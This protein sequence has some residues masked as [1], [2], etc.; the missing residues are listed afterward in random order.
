MKV[1]LL[2]QP[3]GKNGRAPW[4]AAGEVVD[5]DDTKGNFLVRHGIAELAGGAKREP[6]P[7]E[8]PV[9][10]IA[11]VLAWVDEAPEERAQR[12]LAAEMAGKSRKSLVEALEALTAS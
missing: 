6:G 3:S 4:P 12:A 11:V 5:V 1:K 7:D 9:G 10:S 2:E 8:V